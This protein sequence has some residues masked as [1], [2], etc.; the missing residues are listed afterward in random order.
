[1]IDALAIGEA[2]FAKKGIAFDGLQNLGGDLALVFH[3]H[4]GEPDGLHRR[5]S[6]ASPYFGN[7][8]LDICRLGEVV[9][10][11]ILDGPNG[12]FEAR[13]ARENEIFAARLDPAH[14]GDEQKPVAFAMDIEI[15]HEYVKTDGADLHERMG[16]GRDGGN[17]EAVLF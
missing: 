4:G 7:E 16:H 11:L 15:G 12:V 17:I 1:M 8:L 3:E 9:V 14:G 13:I 5:L 10:H 2:R 6:K